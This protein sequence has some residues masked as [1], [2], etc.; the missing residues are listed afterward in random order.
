MVVKMHY[1]SLKEHFEKKKQIF[2]QK[3]IFLIFT[4]KNRTWSRK[5][6]ENLSKVHSMCPE[7]PFEKKQVSENDFSKMEQKIFS[8]VVKTGFYLIRKIYW[9]VF[10][11]KKFIN[12]SS[13]FFGFERKSFGRVVNT[14]IYVSRRTFWVLRKT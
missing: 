1:T 2:E 4:E 12:L 14:E 3:I 7:C 11:K 13:F 5:F 10:S 9:G 6:P 8:K